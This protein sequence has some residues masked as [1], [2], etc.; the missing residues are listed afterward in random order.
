MNQWS[1]K[2][3]NFLTD[4]ILSSSCFSD[5]VEW[6]KFFIQEALEVERFWIVSKSHA[7]SYKTWTHPSC[8]N[9][10]LVS[11]WWFLENICFSNT[12]LFFWFGVLVEVVH[13]S[14]FLM[15]LRAQK[16]PAAIW[17]DFFDLCCG[18]EVSVL[19][20]L[21]GQSWHLQQYCSLPVCEKNCEV[22]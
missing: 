8:V 21:P 18:T 5:S 14:M 17:W 10:I 9:I 22:V 19:L 4:Y 16:N 1:C 11:A 6:Q 2:E 15:L 13:I 3:V 12:Y 20:I 7:T